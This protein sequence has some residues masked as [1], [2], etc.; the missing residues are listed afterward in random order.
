MGDAGA[1]DEAPEGYTRVRCRG[2]ANH[3]VYIRKAV[4]EEI[5]KDASVEQRAGLDDLL[6]RFSAH[7]PQGLPRTKL[8]GNEGWFPSEKASGKVRL[9]AFKPWQL[10][11]Y[12]IV[13]AYL[14]RPS[15]FI[16]GVDCS[17][18]QDRANQAILSSSGAEAL[19]L[20]K[21]I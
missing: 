17:K 4:L 10:R 3:D 13:K 2:R 8:N 7:G 5:N 21:L 12:F 1:E 14:G 6:E 15:A 9:Q 11:A 16:T 19:R 20:S 18:K